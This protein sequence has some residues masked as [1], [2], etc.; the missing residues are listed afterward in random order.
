MVAFDVQL[1]GAEA[2]AHGAGVM[3]LEF[4]SPPSAA[5]VLAS[6]AMAP[7]LGVMAGQWRLAVNHSFVGA[8]HVCQVGDELAVIGLVSGG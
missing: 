4:S 3:R 1:F 6:V 5:E 7:S 8:D 2:S